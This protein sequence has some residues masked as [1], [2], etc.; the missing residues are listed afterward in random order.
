MMIM[1]FE[2]NK[3]QWWV[4]P[5]AD[6]ISEWKTISKKE[7]IQYILHTRHSLDTAD[8]MQVAEFL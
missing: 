5:Q 6:A 8:M 3:A 2:S 1:K 7:F 4:C